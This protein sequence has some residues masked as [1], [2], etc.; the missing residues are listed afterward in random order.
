MILFSRHLLRVVADLVRHAFHT[1]RLGVLF[2]VV[3]GA[4]IAM[5]ALLVEVAGPAIV[6]PF[7]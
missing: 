2:L 4:A 3:I 5:L 1:R 7:I 6:Y